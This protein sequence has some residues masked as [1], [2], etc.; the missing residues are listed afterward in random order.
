MFRPIS[1]LRGGVPVELLLAREVFNLIVGA[2]G[3]K[4]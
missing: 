4:A 3:G 2:G 1:A